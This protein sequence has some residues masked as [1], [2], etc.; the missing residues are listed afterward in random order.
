MLLF[1]LIFTAMESLDFHLP[2]DALGDTSELHAGDGV[3]VDGATLRAAAAGFA[4]QS[5]PPPPSPLPP[6][7]LSAGTATSAAGGSGAAHMLL[8]SAKVM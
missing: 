7:A 3:Y 8:A 1:N 5:V 2:G 6:A 4:L